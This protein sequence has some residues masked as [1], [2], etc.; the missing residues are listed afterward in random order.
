MQ[1]NLNSLGKAPG[2]KKGMSTLEADKTGGWQEILGINKYNLNIHRQQNPKAPTNSISVKSSDRLYSNRNLQF[3]PEETLT[4]KVCV[5]GLLD[6]D[7]FLQ[8]Q[9]QWCKPGKITVL[10]NHDQHGRWTSFS[11]PDLLF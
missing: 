11:C 10:S 6:H 1:L 4:C 3:S 8:G 9:S 7:T 5:D 2:R